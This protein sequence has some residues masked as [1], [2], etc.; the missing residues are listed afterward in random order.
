[1]SVPTKAEA[2]ARLTEHLRLAQE[3]AATLSHLSKL[4]D[5]DLIAQGWLAV[6][7]MFKLTL[8]QVTNLATKGRFH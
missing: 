8:H 7:E 6:S 5:E 3:E 1:M 4:N 2:F